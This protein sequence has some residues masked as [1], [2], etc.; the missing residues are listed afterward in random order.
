[1]SRPSKLLSKNIIFT[2][3]QLGEHVRPWLCSSKKVWIRIMIRRA[4]H[5]DTIWGLWHASKTLL[6]INWLFQMI[7]WNSTTSTCKRS[8]WA[9]SGPWA[10][11]RWRRHSLWWPCMRKRASNWWDRTWYIPLDLNLTTDTEMK[12]DHKLMMTTTMETLLERE[13]ERGRDTSH[14]NLFSIL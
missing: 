12:S 4:I 11:Y 2:R 13:R 14:G 8:G 6:Q 5:V 9:R 10:R 3:N 1:M 7:K